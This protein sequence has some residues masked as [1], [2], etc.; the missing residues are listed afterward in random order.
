MLFLLGLKKEEAALLINSSYF[1]K[2]KGSHN[3]GFKEAFSLLA[4]LVTVQLKQPML[5][6]MVVI[7]PTTKG[8]MGDRIRQI[9][10]CL[11]WKLIKTSYYENKNQ[12]QKQSTQHL[13]WNQLSCSMFSC[14]K[15][16]SCRSWD[17]A[18]SCALLPSADWL[19]RC[20]VSSRNAKRLYVKSVDHLSSSSLLKYMFLGG[21]RHRLTIRDAA[22]LQEMQYV[23][24]S[25]TC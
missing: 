25:C 9:Q 13:A 20:L 21:R 18:E 6:V 16:A 15:L 10:G 19:G 17:P 22:G 1:V 2:N 11:V 12:T 4:S 3:S 5:A 24:I 8:R 23:H 7:C 14:E